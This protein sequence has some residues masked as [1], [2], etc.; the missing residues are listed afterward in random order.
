MQAPDQSAA[1][2]QMIGRSHKCLECLLPAD[3]QNIRNSEEEKGEFIDMLVLGFREQYCPV[4]QWLTPC[5][6][7]DFNETP[8]QVSTVKNVKSPLEKKLLATFI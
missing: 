3:Q 4:E 8:V 6:L 2:Q 5:K 7:L 1:N